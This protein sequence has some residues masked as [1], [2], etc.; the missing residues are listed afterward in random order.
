MEIELISHTYAKNSQP[1]PSS[2]VGDLDGLVDSDVTCWSGI[3]RE[4]RLVLDELLED[5][6]MHV[7]SPDEND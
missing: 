6:K 2:K 3:A 5:A 4:E 7:V 1:S